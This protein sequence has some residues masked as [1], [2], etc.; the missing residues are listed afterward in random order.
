MKKEVSMKFLII[1]LAIRL[2]VEWITG[3]TNKSNVQENGMMNDKIRHPAEY[4]LR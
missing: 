1:V 4:E 2:I 3:K